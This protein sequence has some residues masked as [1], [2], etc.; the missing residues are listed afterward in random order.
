MQLLTEEHI[1]LLIVQIALLLGCARAL[2]EVFRRMGQPSITAEILVGILFGPTIFGRI[3]PDL[4]ARLFP[5]DPYQMKMFGA[6]AWLGILFFLLKAGLET[7]FAT[8]WR[9]RRQ[10]LKLSMFDLTIPMIITFFPCLFLPAR[11]MGAD[12]GRLIFALFIAVIMTISALPVTARVL[13]DLKIYRTDLGLLIMSALTI[14]DVAG[15]IVFALILGFVTEAAGMTLFQ[16]GFVLVSTIA[17]AVFCL[18]LGSKLFDRIL[19]FLHA[20]RVPEPSGS[21][22]LVVVAGL[23]GGITTV[24]IGIH[25]LFGFFIAGIMAGKSNRLSERTRHVFDQMVQ[26]TL[27]PLFFTAVGLKLDFLKNFDIWLVLFILGI[28]MFGRYVA[29]YLG[30]RFIGH[31]SLYSRLI[32]DAH[33]PGGEMQIVIGMLALEYGVISETVYVAVVFGAVFT[34]VISGPL[35]GRLLRRIEQIDW[36]SFLP[37][38]H[39]CVGMA[40]RSREEAIREL[41]ACMHSEIDEHNVD[42]ITQAVLLREQEMTTSIEGGVAIP[43]ARIDGLKRPVVAMGR[44]GQALDWNSADGKPAQLVFLVITPRENPSIQLQ[45][46]RGI[47]CSIA[48]PDVRAKLIQADS[49]SEVMEILRQWLYQS[50]QGKLL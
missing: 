37:V 19:R 42:E 23:L 49:A 36:L 22:T 35:M 30:A 32:A 40:A 26:A 27:V 7:N 25:A 48:D 11:Y 15:W 3:A 1:L 38:D 46:I 5:A 34:S 17:F 13:Q 20:K 50:E 43:H 28:G 41:C 47:S 45:L 8:A 21:L 16:M 12:V 14:N 31:P 29:A 39:I 33:I 9:Q 24:W 4:H 10:A 44:C 6:I 2:G 18:S